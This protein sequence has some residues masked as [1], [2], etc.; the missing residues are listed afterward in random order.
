[1][2]KVEHDDDK[3]NLID[4]LNTLGGGLSHSM[5]TFNREMTRHGASIDGGR[6][7]WQ[8]MESDTSGDGSNFLVRHFHQGVD[9][10]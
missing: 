7:D 10:A 5:A 4:E 6:S 1:M 3:H 2:C 9:E 8:L